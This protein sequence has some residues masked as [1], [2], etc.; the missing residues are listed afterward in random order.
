MIDW[1]CGVRQDGCRLLLEASNRYQTSLLGA[2]RTAHF[3]YLDQ[4]LSVLSNCQSIFFVSLNGQGLQCLLTLLKDIS[5]N[6]MEVIS[7][8]AFT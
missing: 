5:E 1:I 6:M 7:H 2:M 8:F 4:C 3:V